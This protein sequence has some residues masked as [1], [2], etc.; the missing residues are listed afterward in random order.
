LDEAETDE[1]IIGSQR[2]AKRLLLLTSRERVPCTI[3]RYPV[4][5]HVVFKRLVDL[6]GAVVVLVICLPTMALIALGIRLAS[7]GPIL[8]RE[9]RMRLDGNR[10]QMLTFRTM[11]D[12]AEKVTRL[13]LW[14]HGTRLD[15]LPQLFNV[16]WGDMSLVGPRP[17]RPPVSMAECGRHLRARSAIN[18]DRWLKT[19][20]FLIPKQYREPMLGDLIEDRAEMRKRGSSS[21]VIEGSTIIQLLV[22]CACKPKLWIGALLAWLA[23]SISL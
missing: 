23:R 7:A 12:D 21:L 3:W 15:A 2:S 16:L 20:G 22:A 19:G 4:F 9:E 11:V 17:E 8:E 14:L 10:F 18:P 13:G 1:I 6:L 5:K